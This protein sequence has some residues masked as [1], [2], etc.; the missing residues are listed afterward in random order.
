LVL[1]VLAL[2]LRLAPTVP[3][4]YSLQL[5]LQVAAAVAASTKMGLQ[6]AS[7]AEVAA[8]VLVQTVQDLQVQVQREQLTKEGLA[9]TVFT[10]LI[11]PQRV[12][13]V[14]V[15]MQLVRLVAVVL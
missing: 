8:Q 2:L 10:S 6:M 9:V 14:A 5:L 1:A 7:L 3:T 15:Q 12:V 11:I 4:L 13:V